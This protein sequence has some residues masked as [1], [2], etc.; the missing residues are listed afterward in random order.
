M[1]DKERCNNSFTAPHNVMDEKLCGGVVPHLTIIWCLVYVSRTNRQWLFRAAQ[2]PAIDKSYVT[3]W[4]STYLPI[5][6][7]TRTNHSCSGPV[8]YFQTPVWPF[9]LQLEQLCSQAWTPEAPAAVPSLHWSGSL[10]YQYK[11]SAHLWNLWNFA[12]GSLCSFCEWEMID[13]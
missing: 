11:L 5:W 12:A 8:S 10:S 6:T 4:L 2:F 7:W 13:R 1:P 3:A 9:T